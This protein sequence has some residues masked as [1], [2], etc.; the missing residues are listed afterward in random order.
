[1]IENNLGTILGESGKYDQA[2][3]HFA[4]ALRTKPDFLEV[5]SDADI[6]ENLRIAD[7]TSGQTA[8]SNGTAKRGAAIE[9]QQRRRAHHFRSGP[10]KVGKTRTEHSTFLSRA[11]AKARLGS[12]SRQFETRTSANHCAPVSARGNCDVCS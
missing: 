1:M 4:K 7:G 9:S 5:I 2:E 3:A 8:G 10:A 12:R 6:R 11:P